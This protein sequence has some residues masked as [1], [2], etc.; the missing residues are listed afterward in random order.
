LRCFAPLGYHD[1]KRGSY[2][3]G[4]SAKLVRA[5]AGAEEAAEDTLTLEG[6]LHLDL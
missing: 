6:E 3:E 1:G 2:Y 5:G 4:L